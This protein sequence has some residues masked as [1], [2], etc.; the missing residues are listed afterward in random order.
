MSIKPVANQR[1][2]GSANM[3]MFTCLFLLAIMLSAMGIDVA[4]NMLEQNILQNAADSAALAGAQTLFTSTSSATNRLAEARSTIQGIINQYNTAQNPIQIDVNND[5]TF[6]YL[7]PN[8]TPVNYSTFTTPSTSSN[9]TYTG[10]YNAVRVAV[11]KTA[12]SPAGAMPTFISHMFGVNTME[13]AASA[14]AV[15]DNMGVTQMTN[16]LRPFYGCYAQFQAA[17]QRGLLTTDVATIYGSLKLNNANV[18]GCPSYT[19][20]NWGMADLRNSTPNSPGISNIRDWVQYGFNYNGAYN[21]VVT[22]QNYSVQT[23]NAISSMSSQLDSILN[24]PITIPLVDSLSGS[25][26]NTRARVVAFTG[27]VITGYTQNGPASGRE[28]RGYFTKNICTDK[29]AGTNGAVSTVGGGISK[30]RLISGS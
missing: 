3:V 8:V 21:A 5:I 29:C 7:D 16:G 26:S 28:I 9:Y 25:G 27:F 14:T 15:M 10:G 18:A 23:G 20:G 17:Q 19:A 6:G 30:L 4:A 2:A 13:T 11:R 24:K 1:C 22:G 12:S